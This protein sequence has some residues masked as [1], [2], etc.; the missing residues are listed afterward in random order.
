MK[1]I[2]I[3]W[4]QNTGKRAGNVDPRDKNMFCRGWQNMD[5][6]PAVEL[7]EI[8]DGRDTSQYDGVKGITV[9]EGSDAIN[10]AIELNFPSKFVIDEG[11]E[12]NAQD[13]RDF[14]E[15]GC[16]GVRYVFWGSDSVCCRSIHKAIRYR[17]HCY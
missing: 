3:E 13:Q 9:L 1:A 11:I 8:L 12:G 15:K 5:V 6:T 14:R 2:L 7:R 16:K 4:D 10:D 17:R